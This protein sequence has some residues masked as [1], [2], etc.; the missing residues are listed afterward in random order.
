MTSLGPVQTAH[1]QFKPVQTSSHASK[2]TQPAH[3]VQQGQHE[4]T[5]LVHILEKERL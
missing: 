4:L 2:H 1:D 3:A 5:F